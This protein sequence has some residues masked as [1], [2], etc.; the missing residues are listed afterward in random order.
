M[1]RLISKTFA[2]I[3]LSLA[4]AHPAAAAITI[5]SGSQISI[6]GAAQL[7]GPSGG[8]ANQATAIDFLTHG[9][10]GPAAGTLSGYIGM[11]T[12]A[13]QFCDTAC[14]TIN[15]ITSLAVGSSVLPLFT[16]SDGV[17]FALNNI[18]SIDRSVVNVLSFTGTGTFSGTLGGIALNATPGDFV[19]STQGVN[20]TTFSASAD[21]VGPVPEPATWVLMLLG[22]GGIGFAMRRR[23]RPVLAQIA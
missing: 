10:S 1:H 8:A 2:C 15:D 17:I 12:F 16:L 20:L 11:G 14:G 19:F 23:P 21:S 13:G 3:I 18:T 9:V 7:I 22:F 6:N 5:A 4:A